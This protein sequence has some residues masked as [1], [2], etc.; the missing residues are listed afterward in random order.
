MANAHHYRSLQV[1]QPARDGLCVNSAKSALDDVN[2][3][4]LSVLSSNYF[5]A[6]TCLIQ[7]KVFP[8]LLPGE[9]P[10]KTDRT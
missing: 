2:K 7:P 4:I 9:D 8:G 1:F 10:S 5:F 6:A 3:F